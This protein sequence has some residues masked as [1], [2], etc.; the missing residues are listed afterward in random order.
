[1]YIYLY[2]LYNIHIYIYSHRAAA[3]LPSR[4]RGAHVVSAA[5]DSGAGKVVSCGSPG[6][7]GGG[8]RG[9]GWGGRFEARA[10]G[11]QGIL[12]L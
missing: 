1:M 9:V 2:N 3:A 5:G 10:V 6:R 12:P 4:E 8:G 11:R 7:G